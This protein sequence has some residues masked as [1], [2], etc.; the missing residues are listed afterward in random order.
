VQTLSL[1]LSKEI[2]ELVDLKG[3]GQKLYLVGGVVRDFCIGRQNRDID[4]LCDSDTRLIARK[5]ADLNKGAFFMM[6]VQRNT[7]RV[8]LP[9]TDGKRIYDF[10]RFKGA[11]LG[12]D[13]LGRDFTINAMAV[14]LDDPNE[15]IDPLHGREDLQNGILQDC[16]ESSFASDPVRVIRAVRYSNAL[17][18]E[19]EIETLGRLKQN[20]KALDHVSGE[21]KRDELFKILD[22]TRPDDG[23]ERLC[24]LGI[25]TQLGFA[26]VTNFANI[27]KRV[28]GMLKFL[29]NLFEQSNENSSEEFVL[30]ALQKFATMTSRKLAEYLQ[31]K[32][33]SD[34]SNLQLLMLAS[35]LGKQEI[36]DV[37]KVSSRL[38]LSREESEK[39]ILIATSTKFEI[40]QESGNFPSDRE[41]FHYFR[42]TGETGI[43]LAIMS[44]VEMVYIN[45]NN[46]EQPLRDKWIELSRQV[47]AFWFEK[48]EIANPVLL[49]NGNDLMVNFDLT[50]G[51]LIGELIEKLREEQAAGMIKDRNSAMQWVDR[52]LAK[53]ALRFPWE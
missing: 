41:M 30:D 19:I 16:S 40:L 23:F 44:L 38:L 46:V 17:N 51:P 20:I 22:S 28:A 26:Q 10:A 27:K 2:K 11:N 15:I 33:A 4:V 31:K 8:I 25:L 24:E 43:D 52:Q 29:N 37:K 45:A 36:A 3:P 14:D 7:S 42:D 47:I 49:L 48:P 12:D 32:N 39:L 5:F 9:S 1:F 13:L 53:Q 35:I 34:R 21:R 50:P 18:L 6:D